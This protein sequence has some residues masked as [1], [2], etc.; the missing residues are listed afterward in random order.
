MSVSIHCYC[1]NFYA[2]LFKIINLKNVK[3]NIVMCDK[4]GTLTKNVMRLKEC[5]I[6]G[7]NYGSDETEQFNTQSITETLG[8]SENPDVCLKQTYVKI[9]IFRKKNND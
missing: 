5:F 1:I 7:V 6:A 4:T 9:F 8:K 2:K 3:V